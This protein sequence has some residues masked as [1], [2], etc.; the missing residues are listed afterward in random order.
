MM[1]RLGCSPIDCPSVIVRI[2]AIA[3]SG[4]DP[5]GLTCGRLGIPFRFRGKQLGGRIAGL[6]LGDLVS[7]ELLPPN[8]Y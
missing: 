7:S 2:D 4:K 8:N 5:A 1:E 3:I 6:G